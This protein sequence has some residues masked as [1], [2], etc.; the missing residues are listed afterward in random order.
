M[1]LARDCYEVS[2]GFPTSEK[3]GLVSQLRRSAVSVPSNIAEGRG[4]G[5]SREFVRYLNI[6]YGSACEL[7]TQVLIAQGLGMGE[8]TG[9]TR[10]ADGADEVRRMIHALIKRVER[11]HAPTLPS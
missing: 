1:D 11:D 3:F 2:D 8:S 9:L 6:A 4:R 10:V 7:E 5:G